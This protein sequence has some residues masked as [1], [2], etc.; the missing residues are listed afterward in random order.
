MRELVYLRDVVTLRLDAGRCNGCGFCLEVCPREVLA[1][2]GD[3]IEIAAR[4]RC[5]ECGA[6]ALNCPP[7]ALQV[8]AGVG[9]AQAVINSA[10]GRKGDCCSTTD[11]GC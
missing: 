2:A 8:K 9:C 3:K 1:P 10:L 7:G 5:I 11:C 4:D 6:C